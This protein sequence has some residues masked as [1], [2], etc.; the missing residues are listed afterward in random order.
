LNI[1]AVPVFILN[2]L[3]G[4]NFFFL[5]NP[6]ETK[7]LLN[8]FGTGIMYYISLESAALMAFI[9]SYIPMGILGKIE[10][11]QAKKIIGENE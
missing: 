2:I 9:I 3:L 5:A 11:K 4:T 1:I 6:A 10:N 7:T 8:F